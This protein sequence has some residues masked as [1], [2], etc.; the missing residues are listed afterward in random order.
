ME[1]NGKRIKKSNI[2]NS[3]IGAVFNGDAEIKNLTFNIASQPIHEGQSREQ[4]IELKCRLQSLRMRARLRTAIVL[5]VLSL[6]LMAGTSY[7]VR[8]LPPAAS[9]S[10]LFGV[11]LVFA[12]VPLGFWMTCPLEWKESFRTTKR[13]VNII[14]SKIEQI[15]DRIAH[16]EI[17][18]LTGHR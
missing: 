9:L 3:S 15:E 1:D 5:A 7:T 6:L 11:L 13:R 16:L 17:E 18:E 10:E 2:D 4:L 8:L 14:S 12:A